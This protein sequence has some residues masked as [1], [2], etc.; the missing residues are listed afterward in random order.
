MTIRLI[1]PTDVDRKRLPAWVELLRAGRRE[2]DDVLKVLEP[3]LE[4]T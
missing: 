2:F 1:V 3:L 4:E